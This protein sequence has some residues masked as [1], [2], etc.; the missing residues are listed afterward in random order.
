M[1]N[2]RTDNLKVRKIKATGT[3][4]RWLYRFSCSSPL[5]EVKRQAKAAC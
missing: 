3:P 4:C 5:A 2:I 1:Q